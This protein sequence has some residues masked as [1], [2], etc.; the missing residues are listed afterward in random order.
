MSKKRIALLMAVVMVLGVAVGSTMAWLTS[1]PGAVTNTFTVGDITIDLLEH[2]YISESDAEKYAS[3]TEKVGTLDTT[4]DP[5]KAN[6]DYYFVPGDTLPK[7]PYVTVT[8]KS[9]ACWV[10]IEVE[11]K[12]NTVTGLDGKIIQYQV[13]TNTW[14]QVD[15]SNVY[16]KQIT[17]AEAKA[18]V[19]NLYILKG[20]EVATGETQKYPTGCFTVNT[21]VEK[22]MVN[23]INNAKPQLIFNAYAHQSDNT[24]LATAQ[25][26]ALAYFATVP[27]SNP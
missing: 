5:V 17:A 10:F 3:L 15:S 23:T 24:D 13:D 2:T 1:A 8:E 19:A 4:V 18:G 9:E 22:T 21:E 20:D 6:D 27:A 12:N 16:Y 25:A 14:T 26:S 11:E 7:D